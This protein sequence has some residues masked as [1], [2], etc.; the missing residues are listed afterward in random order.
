MHAA[1]TDTVSTGLWVPGRRSLS[2]GLVLTVTLVASESLAIGTI[3]PLVARD[4]SGFDLY[5]WVF[6]SF[7][8]AQLLGIVSSG[9]LI[10]RR[11]GLAM[12]LATGLLCFGAG[13]VI[14]GA[15]PSMPVLIIGRVLQGFGAGFGAPVAYVA[16]GRAYPESAQPRMLAALSA[17]WVLP[18]IFGPALAGLVATATTWRWVFLGL[19]PLLAIAL[20]VTLPPLVAITASAG[21]DGDAQGSQT[22]LLLALA[23]AV[24]AG[25]TLAGL[26]AAA[27]Q[28][29]AAAVLVAAG[30]VVGLPAFSRLVPPGTLQARPVLPA[31]IMLRGLLTFSFAGAEAYVALA[32]VVVRGTSAAEAGLAFTAAAVAWASGAW[33]QARLIER[34]G[35]GW[36]VQA[37]FGLLIVGLAVTAAMV[38]PAVPV[39]AGIA[40]LAIAGLGMGLGYAPLTVTVL[41]EAPAGAEGAASAGLQVTDGLG[42]ALGAGTGGAIIAMFAGATSGAIDPGRTAVGLAATFAVE[43][44]VAIVGLVLC[45]RLRRPSAA[46]VAPSAA[47]VVP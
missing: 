25:L 18:G 46:V 22:R 38:S 13:L 26:G 40:G 20:R 17:A 3:M 8:L 6:S 33:I 30:L 7:F 9:I 4:L 12:P 34:L 35:A 31:A 45:T 44:V 37:G 19:L 16:I 28:P 14:G 43:I 2:L 29:V 41:R 27:G 1:P 24:G 11:G 39:A 42:T 5:G 21:R 36:L 47:G 10:D 23:I 15:A 32:F